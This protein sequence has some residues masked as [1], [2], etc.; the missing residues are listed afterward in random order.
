MTIQYGDN[1]EHE[2]EPADLD[3]TETLRTTN[4]RLQESVGSLNTMVKDLQARLD[5]IAQP[6][7]PPTPEQQR[8][9]EAKMIV[10]SCRDMKRRGLNSRNAQAAVI[11]A[12]IERKTGLKSAPPDD[13]YLRPP[14]T[15]S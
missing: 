7:E 3:E 11:G 2:F 6:P 15:R 1:N 10:D 4:Q 5:E 12:L 14:G 13:Q 8:A 9:E